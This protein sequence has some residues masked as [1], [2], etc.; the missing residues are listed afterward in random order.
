MMIYPCNI[1]CDG[2]ASIDILED[3]ECAVYYEAS[4]RDGYEGP[5]SVT[6][7][8]EDQVLET[9]DK[10]MLDDVTVDAIAVSSVSN[11]AGGRT[12]YIGGT[13]NYG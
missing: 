5:Y 1:I 13:V 4:S 7:Q 11:P 2:D 12:V 9:K 6:P 10:L 8:F 3:G